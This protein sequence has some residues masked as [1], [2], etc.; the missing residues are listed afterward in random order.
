MA[1]WHYGI[2]LHK[3]EDTS[4]SSLLN[5]S[6]DDL[7]QILLSCGLI[8][9]Q[10]YTVKLHLNYWKTFML[11]NHIDKYYFDKF[12]VT[13]FNSYNTKMYYMCIGS[14]RDYKLT[15]SS[16]FLNNSCPRKSSS[17]SKFIKKKYDRIKM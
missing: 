2:L 9:Y 17:L 7:K 5:T 16:Q 8:Y 10:G 14:E 11:E 1:F 4:L 12:N 3:H 13:R 15:P 6:L